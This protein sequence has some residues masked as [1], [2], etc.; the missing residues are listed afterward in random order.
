MSGFL[1]P[2][3]TAPA[4]DLDL[5]K[6]FQ[7]TVVGITGLAGNLVRPRWQKTPP[8]QPG[9]DTDWIA[10]G[11]VR[12]TPDQYAHKRQDPTNSERTILR[13]H[14]TIEVLVSCYGP[15]GM[16]LLNRLRNG[17]LMDANRNAL[18][19]YG[20]AFQEGGDETNVP[21][22]VNQQWYRRVDCPLTFRRQVETSYAGPTILTAPITLTPN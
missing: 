7:A 12:Q 15:N 4:D 22:L 16:S 21:E 19:A 6:V 5:D 17:L 3:T 9:P 14:V 13:R 11:T 8:T 20:I 1:P 2:L 10:L 18:R